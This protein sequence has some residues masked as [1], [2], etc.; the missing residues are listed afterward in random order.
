MAAKVQPSIKSS[1]LSIVSEMN[2]AKAVRMLIFIKV[3]C[4]CVQTR[5]YHGY[6]FYYLGRT[7]I[8]LTMCQV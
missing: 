7:H 6:L 8:G 2:D 4:D 5:K 1:A 3:S